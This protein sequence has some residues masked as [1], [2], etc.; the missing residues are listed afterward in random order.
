LF[1]PRIYKQYALIP[2]ILLGVGASE[3]LTLVLTLFGFM[4]HRK[5]VIF[6]LLCVGTLC[7]LVNTAF[8]SRF[9]MNEMLHTEKTSADFALDAFM[10]SFFSGAMLLAVSAVDV[11]I[12]RVFYDVYSLTRHLLS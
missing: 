1:I 7:L 10:I 6:V 4:Q 8:Y 9:I 12:I 3:L 11:A 2:L 5:S